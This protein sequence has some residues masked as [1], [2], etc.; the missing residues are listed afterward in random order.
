MADLCRERLGREKFAVSTES[1]MTKQIF[2]SPEQT[3]ARL[4]EEGWTLE[5]DFG[6]SAVAGP[7]WKRAAEGGAVEFCLP[8]AAHHVNLGGVL[9]G[10][11]LMSFADRAIGRIARQSTG[12]GRAVTAQLDVNFIDSV[13]IGEVVVARPEVVRGTRTVIFMRCNFTVGERVVATAQGVWKA[14]KPA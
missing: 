6:F 8:T 7:Y 2:P 1:T 14:L 10:G 4:A 9:H 13:Q 3:A 12:H 11:A 5:E